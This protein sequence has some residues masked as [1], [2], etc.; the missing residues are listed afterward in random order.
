MKS[1]NLRNKIWFYLII[2]SIT[3]LSFLWL[4]QVIFLDSYYEW[5]KVKEI[6]KIADKLLKNDNI[7]DIKKT[8]DELSFKEGICIDVMHSNSEVYSSNS[9]NRGCMGLSSNDPDYLRNKIDF[10]N[11]DK[12][13]KVYKMVNTRF[14]N[15]IVMYGVRL[16]DYYYIFINSSIEALSST[17]T[18]LGSQLIYVTIIVMILSLLI[19]YFISKR[20]SKPIIK[21]NNTAKKMANGNYNVNFE[22]NENIHE[23]NELVNTLNETKEQLSKTD[24]IRRELLAN[25]SHD[26]KTPLTMIKAYAEM[27]KDI[28][29]KDK[30]KTFKN[31]NTIIDETDRLNLLVNDILDLSKIQS[32]AEKII[33]EEV[34]LNLLIESVLDRFSYLIETKKYI[35]KYNGIKNILIQAD[36]KKIEQVIYNLISNASNYVGDDKLIIVNLIETKNYYRVEVIDRGKGIKKEDLNLI[37]DK[38]YKTDKTH[39]RNTIGTG[40]GLSIVKNILEIHNFKYGV[41]SIKNKGTTFYFEIK[42]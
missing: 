12:D 1:N 20:I 11:S 19:S 22:I 24:T 18:I 34:D 29:Y 13:K 38:Y 27:I 16:N 5:Y 40:L 7:S 15:K 35:I 14:N 30:E 2:F 41:N 3:T 36:K 26:L 21:I 37:W 17:T 42:R 25:I 4:F 39:N 9:L 32:N 8:L 28:S 31:L 33:F 23:L 6:D 10:K